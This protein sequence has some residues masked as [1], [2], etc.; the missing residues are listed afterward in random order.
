MQ[1][2]TFSFLFLFLFIHEVFAANPGFQLQ[3]GDLLF[4]DLNCGVLCNGISE[5]TEGVNHTQISHVGMVENLQGKEPLVVE[6]VGQGVV[7][8]PLSTFLARSHDPEGRPMVMVERV[9]SP[10]QALIPEAIAY[11][12]LQLGKPYNATFVPNDGQSFY[13]S[14]LIA[15]AFSFANHNHAIFQ[16]NPMNFTNLKTHHITTAWQTYFGT[17]YAKAPQGQLGT[18]PGMM[19]RSPDLTIVYVYGKIRR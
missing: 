10:Y 17:L 7:N 12:E 13:C 15:A 3:S 6:A 11:A 18:N 5:V 8:T 14:Q 2:S 9:K 16:T 19:S 1:S 4:Q